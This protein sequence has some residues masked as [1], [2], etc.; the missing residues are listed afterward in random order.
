M[1]GSYATAT[2]EGK[3]EEV[4]PPRIPWFRETVQEQPNKIA[5]RPLPIDAMCMFLRFVATVV[6]S[7]FSIFFCFSNVLDWF[8]F[9]F[10]HS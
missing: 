3:R 10:F 9:W 1:I 7:I 5:G 6:C 8:C 4:V 2:E